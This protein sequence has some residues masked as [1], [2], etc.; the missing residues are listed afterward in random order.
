MRAA[1]VLDNHPDVVLTCGHAA[2]A[3]EGKSLP[4]IPFQTDRCKYQVITGQE[5]IGR[6]CKNSN[7]SP[8][9]TPTAV[10]RTSIQ[11]KIGGYN[12]DLP[13]A[14]DLEMWLRFACYGS[15]CFLDA[16]QAYYRKHGSNMHEFFV[17]TALAN[18]RQHLCA[19]DSVFLNH[20]DKIADYDKLQEIYRRSFALDAL[21]SAS[22]A[23]DRREFS[24]FNEYLA[25]S[26]A[27]NPR[28]RRSRQWYRL[29]LKKLLGPAIAKQLRGIKRFLRE[30]IVQA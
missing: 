18:N 11:K 13:H 19:F 9:W 6:T 20:K 10:V 28:I 25:F 1:H 4:E 23:L 16:F 17:K 14:G 12:K 26:Y 29:Q 5:F 30:K 3:E 21:N 8:L 27:V 22:R 24:D 2:V 7:E 15:V